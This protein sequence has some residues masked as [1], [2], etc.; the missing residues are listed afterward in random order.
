MK[1]ITPGEPVMD[2]ALD[3]MSDD[4]TS[5]AEANDLVE[6]GREDEIT[7]DPGLATGSLEDDSRG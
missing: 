5:R 2:G 6:E 4:G 7:V 3:D 1:N